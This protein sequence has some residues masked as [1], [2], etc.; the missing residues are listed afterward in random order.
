MAGNFFTTDPDSCSALGTRLKAL[1]NVSS[2]SGTVSG[3]VPND[4]I[5][6]DVAA[7][8]LEDKLYCLNILPSQHNQG[9]CLLA[10]LQEEVSGGC[11]QE[12][13]AQITY[14]TDGTIKV[15]VMSDPDCRFSGRAVIDG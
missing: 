10:S 4:C 13:G 14:K 15:C 9:T 11:F 1:E 2:T 12:V 8:N 6:F 5:I 3:G 7:W